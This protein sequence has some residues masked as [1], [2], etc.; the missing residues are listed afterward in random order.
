VDDFSAPVSELV[1]EEFLFAMNI[2]ICN[3]ITACLQPQGF[4][5]TL[6]EIIL[7]AISF[8]LTKKERQ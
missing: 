5:A 7:S 6:F 8:S 1:G 3:G 4:V 2:Q